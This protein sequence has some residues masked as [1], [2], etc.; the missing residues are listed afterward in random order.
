[1]THPFIP[2]WDIQEENFKGK[3]PTCYN[4]ASTNQERVRPP[5][6]ALAASGGE[7]LCVQRI[8]GFICEAFIP[9]EDAFC[10]LKAVIHELHN[11]SATQI[12][13][14]LDDNHTVTANYL[15]YESFRA[16]TRIR[17]LHFKVSTNHRNVKFVH[18][19]HIISR[20]FH[21][22]RTWADVHDE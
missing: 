2:L 8:R 4:V 11:K 21:I 6:S 3:L 15:W 17:S 1:M 9:V 14:Q 13:W 10:P 5:A 18:V 16:A 7:F 19:I 22:R 12:P 20:H